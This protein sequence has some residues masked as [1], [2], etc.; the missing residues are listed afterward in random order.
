M[1]SFWMAGFEGADHVNAHG[2]ATDMVAISGHAD[3][4]DEDFARLKALGLTTVRESI[5][6]RL[7]EPGPRQPGASPYDFR[8]TLAMARAAERHGIQI[9]WTLMHYGVPAGASLLDDS[10]VERFATFADAVARTLEPYGSQPPV[11]TPINEI[12]Y[13][14]WSACETNAIHPH[15]GDRADPRWRPMPDGFEV[16]RRLVRATLAAIDAIRGASPDA[17]FLH[18]DPLVH[19]VAPRDAEPALVAEAAR[20]REFQWQAWDMLTGRLEPGLGGSADALDFV[21][22][23]HYVT[24]QWEFGTGATLGWPRGTG[25]DD[26]RLPFAS[27]LRE[28]WLRYGKP[29]VVAETGNVGADRAPW[30]EEIASE[31]A[32]AIAG[33]VPVEGICLYP[34][35]DRPSWDDHHFWHRSGLF[36][37]RPGDDGPEVGEIPG[38]HLHA[39]LADALA[40]WRAGSP[41]G[42]A[43]SEAVRSTLRAR[44]V[45]PA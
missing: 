41:A 45:A 14:A 21:G 19:V 39:P 23:N 18:V 4:I 34:A 5:G 35:L 29:V 12:S 26:R 13:L 22:V 44:D 8:R 32:Q 15:V 20:F 1:H 33:G 17:R 42:S 2:L 11:F 24:A 10:L 28:A 36:D 37:A 3:A 9:L 38:R 7:A 16:K 27:L 31:V 43:A 40:R 25:G 30:F 6:W